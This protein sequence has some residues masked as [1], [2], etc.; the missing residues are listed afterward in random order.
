MALN[1][2]V[3]IIGLSRQHHSWDYQTSYISLP[4]GDDQGFNGHI[5]T[6]TIGFSYYFGKHEN[7][8]DW[9]PTKTVSNADLDKLTPEN[10]KMRQDL[11]DDHKDGVPNYLDQQLD[12][13]ENTPVDTRGVADPSKMDSDQDGIAD[14]YDA[15]PNEKRNLFYKRLSR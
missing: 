4:K 12:T 13:H 10:E 6:G 5:F 9:S 11:M 1:I 15:C 3:S 14:L 7:H 2:D 8:A